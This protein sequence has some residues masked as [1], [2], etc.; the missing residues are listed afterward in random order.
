MSQNEIKAMVE[1]LKSKGKMHFLEA[2]TKEQLESY[3]A[4]NAILLPHKYKEWLQFSDGGEFFLPAGVQMYGVAHKPVIDIGYDNKPSDNYVVIGSLA[5]GDPVLCEK[6]SERI[7]IYN[8][9]AG[10]IEDD[11][12]YEDFFAFMKDMYDFLGIGG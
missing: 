4:K 3:E 7:S 6:D 8:Q 5:S 1:E 11:E 9:E 2:A 10:C 12:V